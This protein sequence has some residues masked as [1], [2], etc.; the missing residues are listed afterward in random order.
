M[1]SALCPEVSSF[2]PTQSGHGE[3][4]VLPQPRSWKLHQGRCLLAKPSSPAGAEGHVAG[5][6][7][8]GG[9]AAF[10]KGDQR[11]GE[12]DRRNK[13]TYMRHG[14]SMTME[15]KIHP[16]L[17]L[18]SYC[19]WPASPCTGEGQEPLVCANREVNPLQLTL[20]GKCL[21]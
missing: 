1:G 12:G 17:T 21:I 4:S 15:K 2:S 19:P 8:S 20:M 13:P 10:L 14:Y 9:D 18:G 16:T 6:G 7:G 5:G 3:S 11:K